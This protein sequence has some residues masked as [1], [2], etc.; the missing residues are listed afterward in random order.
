MKHWRTKGDSEEEDY[1]KPI[2]KKTAKNL[3]ADIDRTNKDPEMMHNNCRKIL[4]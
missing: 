3:S 4:K 2:G 1:H